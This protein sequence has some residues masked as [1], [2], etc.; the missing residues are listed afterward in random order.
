MANSG[1]LP[2]VVLAWPGPDREP[3]R[4]VNPPGFSREEEAMALKIGR[5][6][7]EGQLQ[8][9]CRLLGKDA[10]DAHLSS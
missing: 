3:R 9:G 8:I 6:L 5:L 1:R 10:P 4:R 7:D 2:A